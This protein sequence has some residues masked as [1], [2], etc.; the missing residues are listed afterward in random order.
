MKNKQAF[1]LIELLVV[2]LI[3]G[4]L[5][6]V[7]LPQYKLAVAKSHLATIRPVVSSIKQAVETY[8]M[9]NGAYPPTNIDWDTLGLELSSCSSSNVASDV[10]Q[11]G[12]FLI[13]VNQGTHEEKVIRAGY[14]PTQE[15]VTACLWSSNEFVYK[16]WLTHS[17]HPDKVECTGNT[18]LGRKVCNS[19]H[20]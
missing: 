8:Y 5:A 11:C 14:C 16:V 17:T 15:K 2:V 3:I 9:A 6:A 19:L 12:D 13:D 10:K 4:I 1:T 18:D 7:A 20:L